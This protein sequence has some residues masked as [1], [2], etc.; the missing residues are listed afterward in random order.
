MSRRLGLFVRPK[1]Q[2]SLSN[3]ESPCKLIFTSG[4]H[5]LYEILFTAFQYTPYVKHNLQLIPPLHRVC[6]Y[7]LH[8]AGLCYQSQELN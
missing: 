8:E 3:K 1:S 4:R 5:M 2:Q 7:V 6:R